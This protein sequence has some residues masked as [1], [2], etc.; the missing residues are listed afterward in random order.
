MADA[1]IEDAM[2]M[3]KERDQVVGKRDKEVET[4][5][6]WTTYTSTFGG[7]TTGIGTACI[8][9][10]TLGKST[11]TAADVI[12]KNAFVAGVG[13]DYFSVYCGSRWSWELG[14]D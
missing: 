9:A 5:R 3:G 11:D 6:F 7:T 12:A 1:Q 8:S 2:F 13:H 4:K 14:G 10:I